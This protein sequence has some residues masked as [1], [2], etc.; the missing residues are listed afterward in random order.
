MK[1][2]LALICGPASLLFVTVA[3]A[4]HPATRIVSIEQKYLQQTFVMNKVSRF[5]SDDSAHTANLT[6]RGSA[7]LDNG[8]NSVGLSGD[9]VLLD[10]NFASTNDAIFQ[11]CR[12]GLAKSQ[13][14]RTV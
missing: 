11:Q 6:G 10:V 14:P 5:S 9:G 7:Q 1:N 3:W 2:I 4:N 8:Q 13:P 12:E